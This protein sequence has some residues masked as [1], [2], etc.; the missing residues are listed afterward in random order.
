[1][2]TVEMF[3]SVLGASV[4]KPSDQRAETMYRSGFT[5]QR[6]KARFT[7]HFHAV[8]SRGAPFAPVFFIRLRDR[9]DI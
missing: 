1:M 3:P 2:S 4:D 5:D 9:R 7:E 6:A 8:G